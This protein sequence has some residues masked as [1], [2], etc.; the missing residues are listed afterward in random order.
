MCDPEQTLRRIRPLLPRMGITRLADVTWLDDIGVPVYQAVRPNSYLMSVSQGKGLSRAHAIVSAAME[1]I[2]SWHAERVGEGDLVAT[3]GEVEPDL[4]YRLDELTLAPRHY[5]NPAAKLRWTRAR[6]LLGGEETLVPTDVLDLDGRITDRWRPPLFVKSS[7]GLASGN[8]LD[9]AVLHGLYEVIERDALTRAGNGP[10]RHL[11]DSR[12]V[13][14]ESGELFRRLRD[15][16][17]DA[18]ADL[19]PSPTGL[20]CFRARIISD[21]F[22]VVF[23]GMGCHFDR[24][25]ALCRAL[26]EAVQSRVTTIAGTR[27]DVTGDRFVRAEG[28]SSGRVSRPDLAQWS[29]G[30]VPLSFVDVESRRHGTIA[31]DLRLAGELVQAHTGRDPLVVDHTRPDIGIPVARV[32]C[33]GLVFN[34]D[35]V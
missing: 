21:S 30:D 34:P 33:P 11:V 13:D 26:T 9:E 28:I 12:T 16:G 2:E 10:V 15:A 32:V 5:L 4:A 14:G 6:H 20:P 25:V 35:L 1:S 29:T 19:L 24:D 7:N 27:D 23:V 17:V 22:P 31:E 18:A 3:A 8:I